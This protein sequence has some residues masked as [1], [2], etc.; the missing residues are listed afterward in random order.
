MTTYNDDFTE[1]SKSIKEDREKEAKRI[2]IDEVINLLARGVRL[3]GLPSS[4]AYSVAIM[5]ING[6]DLDEGDKIQ[7]REHF[8]NAVIFTGMSAMN[9]IDWDAATKARADIIKRLEANENK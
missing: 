3:Y 2:F 6:S 4:Y 1:L 5:L 7:H 8:A 9:S